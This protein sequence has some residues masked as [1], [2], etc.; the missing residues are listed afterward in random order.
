MAMPASCP[1][2]EFVDDQSDSIVTDLAYDY[3]GRRLASVSAD[4]VIRIRDLDDNGVWC[5]EEGCE[6]KPAHQGTLWKVDWAHPGFGKQLLATCSQ[7]RTVKIWEEHSEAAP[8]QE[9]S[10]IGLS[11]GAPARW[12]VATTLKDSR[13]GVVDVKFAPRHLGLRIASASEDG[14]VRVYKATD[15]S[16]VSG[17]K[18]APWSF[19]PCPDGLGVTCISWCSSP[20]LKPLLVVGTM[21]GLVQIWL[22]DGTT[23]E[24]GKWSKVLDLPEHGSRGVS[25]VS[26][27]PQFCTTFDRIATCGGDGRVR[28]HR[29]ERRDL[30]EAAW[31]STQTAHLKDEKGETKGVAWSAEWDVN[32]SALCSTDGN[33][34][35][36]WISE[37][38][39]VSNNWCCTDVFQEVGVGGSGGGGVAGTDR[40]TAMDRYEEGSAPAPPATVPEILEG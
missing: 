1:V 13:Y 26:W 14:H 34:C 21:S 27:S 38:D 35:R 4:G 16:S 39:G 32:G 12:I 10:G 5:V 9:R 15:L 2:L 11:R 17:W 3:H 30:A 20:F 37:G 19:V 33:T 8:G 40:K 24:L 31:A 18:M 28:V 23:E 25:S 36:T 29:L 6:I 22:S 7:D